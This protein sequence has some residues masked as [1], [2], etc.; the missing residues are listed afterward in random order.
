MTYLRTGELQIAAV[1][2]VSHSMPRPRFMRICGFAA[3]SLRGER[4]IHDSFPRKELQDYWSTHP[5]YEDKREDPVASGSGSTSHPCFEPETAEN[6]DNLPPPPPYSLVDENPG[7]SS[8]S[9]SVSRQTSAGPPLPPRTTRPGDVPDDPSLSRTASVGST[10]SAPPHHEPLVNTTSRPPA[11]NVANRPHSVHS[12]DALAEQMGRHSIHGSHSP[13]PRPAPPPGRPAPHPYGSPSSSPTSA[14][15]GPWA[16]PSSPPPGG[17]A[18]AP[19]P[20][21]QWG[22]GSSLPQAPPGQWSYPGEAYRNQQQYGYAPPPGPPPG[23]APPPGP[24]PGVYVPQSSYGVSNAPPPPLRPRPSAHSH[25]HSHSH[26]PG[27][28]TSEEGTHFPEPFQPPSPY[29]PPGVS[30][31]VSPAHT[32]FPVPVTNANAPYGSFPHGPGKCPAAR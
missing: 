17:W 31:P 16:P 27:R 26:S 8:S 21:P 6:V 11:P 22:V 25:S 2:M 1:N 15:Q 28:P 29:G 32:S 7:S 10:T 4:T 13:G 30:P 23:F 18:Q 19:W 3:E 20:P 24:P 5:R 14:A 9:P 12:I